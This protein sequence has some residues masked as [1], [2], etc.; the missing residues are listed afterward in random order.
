MPAPPPRGPQV[1]PR[2]SGETR[3]EQE[4][5][6]RH[7]ILRLRAPNSGLFTL[8]GTNTWVV[9]RSPAWV[10]DPGPAL[11]AHMRALMAAFDARGGLGGIALTH[12][13]ADHSQAVGA[14]REQ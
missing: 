8:S 12:D 14:L 4:L 5:L 2:E 3:S 13:H 10:I 7:D 11:D 6:N 1:P 9:G